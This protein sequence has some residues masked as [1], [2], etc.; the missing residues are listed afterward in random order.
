MYGRFGDHLALELAAARALGH[1][2][3]ERVIAAVDGVTL[4]LA[5]GRRVLNFCSNDYLGLARAPWL[6]EEARSALD[7]HGLGVASTRQNSGTRAVHRTLEREL[8]AFLR[9]DDAVLFASCYAAN[10]GLFAAL[11]DRTDALLHDDDCHP[12]IADGMRLARARTLPFRHAQLDDLD[13]RLHEAAGARF[14][15]VATDG[16]FPADGEVAPLAGICAAAERHGALVLV[17]DAHGTG[18]VGAHGRGTAEL[19]GTEGRVDVITGTLSKCF[20]GM[21][22]GFVATRQAIA[23][24]LRQRARPYLLSNSLAPLV[25]ATALAALRRIAAST[26]LRDRLEATTRVF[27]EG[28]AAAGFD[29]DPGGHPIVSVMLYEAALAQRFAADLLARGI[30]VMAQVSPVV[31]QGEA[32][33]RVQI[34]AAHEAHE[35]ERA[36]TAFAEVGRRHA[37]V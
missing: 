31:P 1:L 27:R 37:I 26:E 28:M 30:L 15:L 32:R 9:M 12:S 14:C 21:S 11:F 10:I 13:A 22:G 36:M 2:R 19:S 6:F 5:D 20:G 23:D 34:S 17:D 25:A 16:V 33:L 18:I 35:I 24:A 3:T 8:A 4:E 7:E 29:I